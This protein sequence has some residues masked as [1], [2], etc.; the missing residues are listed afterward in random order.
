MR[1]NTR[2]WQCVTF[3][4]V[5]LATFAIAIVIAR[6]PAQE[7]FTPQVS[8]ASETGEVPADAVADLAQF[9]QVD[10]DTAAAVQGAT[11]TSIPDTDPNT[12]FVS[13]LIGSDDNDG[14]TAEA[15]LASLQG[16]INR[17]AAGQTL[18]VMDGT[19][20]ELA[21]PG[22]AHYTIDVDG[23]PDAWITIAAALGH[24]PEVVPSNGNGVVVRG[25]YIELQGLKIRGD[26]FGVDNSYG[27]GVLIRDSHHVR[28]VGNNISAMP[29][30]GVA[31]VESANLE[32]YENDV[33]DNSFW[34]TEQGSGISI[35]RSKDHGTEPST[36]GYHDKIVGN[37]AYRNE[38][39]VFSR[40][41]TGQNAITD[42]NGIIIDG[43]NDL[44]YTGRTLVA[45]NLSFDN[46]GRGILVYLS[47]RVDVV[48][49][50]TYL[51]GR[52]DGLA[53]GPSELSVGRSF[54]VQVLNNLAWARPG[55]RGVEIK[56]AD[57]VTMGGNVFVT[58]TVTGQET[59]LD[60]VVAG[61]P[62]LVFASVDPDQADFSPAVGSMLIDLAIQV[63]PLVD[64][65]AARN[66]RD[67]Q[68][69]DVGAFE[70]LPN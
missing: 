46:G 65:D 20:S 37:R 34:G 35:W 11:T 18:Y 67:A 41:V 23:A 1:I 40:W 31:A 33:Y 9:A 58:D 27:W 15:P 32:L 6:P 56:E 7:V 53:G 57:G 64:V 4:F 8:T 48:F 45:N 36:D 22:N 68:G 43:S 70:Y 26:S 12:F 21:E 16:A 60:H 55:V 14:Q 2:V 38:N 24:N 49:N 19:Y 47:S 28:I 52:T 62:G 30:G 61:D 44:D 17:L 5:V 25:D 13:S 50:T 69:F 10:S 3:A 29:V 51:N 54:D 39:K 66:A 63:E 59:D 42:G